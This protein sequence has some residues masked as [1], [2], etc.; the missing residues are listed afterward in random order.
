MNMSRYLLLDLLERDHGSIEEHCALFT[1]ILSFSLLDFFRD[2]FPFAFLKLFSPIPFFELSFI[3]GLAAQ[4]I[5]SSGIK[6]DAKRTYEAL[7][8]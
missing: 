4:N 3:L 8:P 5:S 7:K 1:N 2:I 6:H